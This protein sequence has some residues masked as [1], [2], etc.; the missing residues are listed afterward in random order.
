MSAAVDAAASKRGNAKRAA[1]PLARTQH[2]LKTADQQTRKPDMLKSGTKLE[3]LTGKGLRD[4]AKS[5]GVP[6]HVIA[7]LT[8]D[9]LRRECLF[10][11]QAYLDEL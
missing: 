8:E 11:V 6:G 3:E 5:A 10:R 1:P 4:Y 7:S 9:K 2:E